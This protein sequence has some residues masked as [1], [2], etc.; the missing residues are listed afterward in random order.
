M[1]KSI[2]LFFLMLVLPISLFSQFEKLGG[3][4]KG[5]AIDMVFVNDTT[6]VLTSSSLQYSVDQGNSWALV[7]G[8]NSLPSTLEKVVI[9]NGV[10]YISISFFHIEN[11]IYKTE[12]FGKTWTQVNDIDFYSQGSIQDFDAYN[13]TLYIYA[14]NTT[15]ISPDR[16]K[17]YTTIK[18][19]VQTFPFLVIYNKVMHIDGYHYYLGEGKLIKTRDFIT[20]DVIFSADPKYVYRL[21]RNETDI[22]LFE[23]AYPVFNLYKLVGNNL[24]KQNIGINSSDISE[25]NPI[26]YD[27]NMFYLKLSKTY[28]EDVWLS[29]KYLPL[30]SIFKS[31]ADLVEIHNSVAYVHFQNQFYKMGINDTI[32]INITNNMVADELPSLRKV[33]NK[34]LCETQP[35]SYFDLDKQD[36]YYLKNVPKMT[37][38]L[39]D[40][41]LVKYASSTSDSFMITTLDDKLIKKVKLPNGRMYYA[42]YGDYIGCINNLIFVTYQLN[43]FYVSSDLGNSWKIIDTGEGWPIEVNYSNNNIMTWFNAGPIYRAKDN[44]NFVGQ[45]ITITNSNDRIK[46]ASIDDNGTIFYT[47]P[48]SIY[49]YNMDLS[50]FETIPL[51]PN[52]SSNKIENIIKIEHYKN[53]LF[54]GGFG[55]G[56]HISYNEGKSWLPFNDGLESTNITSIEIDDEYIYVGTYCHLYKRRLTDLNGKKVIGEVYEDVNENGSREADEK[57]LSNIY[58]R[59]TENNVIT[60]SDINGQF[61]F[62]TD[63]I[64]DNKVELIV[65][66]YAKATNGQIDIGGAAMPIQLGLKYDQNAHD[67]EIKLLN[68]SVFRPGFEVPIDIYIENLSINEANVDVELT[69]DDQLEFLTVAYQPFE[70]DGNKLILRNI[71]IGAREISI[72]KT[73]FN[74]LLSS[75]IGQSVTL[76]ANIILNNQVDKDLLNNV[77]EHTDIVRGSFDPNDKLVYPKSDLD[78]DENTEKKQLL[79]TIRFQNTGNY[80]ADFVR[81]R[82]TLSANLDLRTLKILSYS[83]ACEWKVR[84]GRVLEVYFANINLVDSTTSQS[85]SRGYFTFGIN[86]IENLDKKAVVNNKADIYFDYNAPIITNTVATRLKETSVTYQPNIE[87]MI[88]IPNPANKII[89]IENCSIDEGMFEILDMLGKPCTTGIW[90]KNVNTVINIEQLIPGQYLIKIV[91]NKK[92]KS[93]GAS[94]V[95][96]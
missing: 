75:I 49:K 62:V 10:I 88:I 13:D 11:V 96:I 21:F 68:H 22:F 48:A 64:P 12:D 37:Y 50:K 83:H 45:P 84:P 91:D 90:K 59:T 47:N 93:A 79:Y 25:T 86:L 89:S 41:L 2:K 7:P 61:D 81:L 39:N 17:T 14:I 16:G 3:P 85:L 70:L 44:I 56:L 51:P 40:S 65:P 33:G 43:K 6:Y 74:T 26:E 5:K 52:N 80:P 71:T 46:A 8:S 9:D 1:K 4:R 94:F 15:Y 28:S 23:K 54:A 34:L 53:I 35:I 82:D 63:S 57:S 66:K 29:K 32:P 30:Y 24:V 31:D 76:K 19:M 36:W 20:N 73:S 87:K 42:G 95:K 55:L 72:F 67:V 69:F 77:F 92:I 18:P 78:F 58:V 38:F 60:Q 27:G